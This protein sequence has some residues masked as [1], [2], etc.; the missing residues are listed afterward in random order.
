M[1]LKKIHIFVRNLSTMKKRISIL[2]GTIIVLIT[3]LFVS[4]YF[5]ISKMYQMER[6]LMKTQAL[7]LLDN[8]LQF[9]LKQSAMDRFDILEREGLLMKGEGFGGSFDEKTIKIYIVYPEKKE[10]KWKM[11]TEEEWYE[12]TKERYGRYHTSGINLARLDSAFKSALALK[13]ITTPYVL[14]IK[15]SSN[16]ILNSSPSDVNFERYKLSIESIRLDIDGKDSLHARFDESYFGAF[17]QSR[18]MLFVSS[19]FALLVSMLLFYLLQTILY[20]K[21]IAED[22]E[23]ISNGI[24][25]NLRKPVALIR[26]TLSEME[27]G[28]TKNQNDIREMAFENDKLMMMLEMLLTVS[29]DDET[30]FIQQETVSLNEFIN[31]IINQYNTNIEKTVIYFSSDKHSIGVCIDRFHFEYALRNLIDN[32]I[33]YSDGIPYIAINCYQKG[34]YVY[35]TV[36]DHGIG[37]PSKYIK[38]IFKK[39]YRA[40]EQKA[41]QKQG[42]GIGLYYVMVIVKKHGGEVTV[43]SEYGKGSLFT[44]K[45][46]AI[47]NFKESDI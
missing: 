3:G 38:K 23:E 12:Y 19:G 27:T 42:F 8:R 28:E 1:F 39:H 17:R 44:L 30:Q 7:L 31:D 35:I 25:H 43:E 41:V 5:R 29:H 33:K 2:L 10:L 34:Y 14:V 24:I 13:G 46:P 26:R 32:A 18:V 15:D 45:I 36:E 16:V 47:I 6:N 4:E 37:I 22:K 20:Q 21:K 11:D 40:P 9:E